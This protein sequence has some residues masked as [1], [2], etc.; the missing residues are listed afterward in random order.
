MNY[1]AVPS[2]SVST[3]FIGGEIIPGQQRSYARST[4][5]ILTR[6]EENKYN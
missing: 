2:V 3:V 6:K 5:D 1:I 4:Y